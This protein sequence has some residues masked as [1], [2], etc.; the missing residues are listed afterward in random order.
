[1]LE[2]SHYQVRGL[3][4]IYLSHFGFQMDKAVDLCFFSDYT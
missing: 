2:Y 1:M 3:V 4:G